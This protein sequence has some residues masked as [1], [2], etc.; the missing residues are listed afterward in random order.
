MSVNESQQRLAKRKKNA[1]L[2]AKNEKNDA[3]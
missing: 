1:H 2:Q 3:L